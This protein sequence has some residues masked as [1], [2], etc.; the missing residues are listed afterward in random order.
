MQTT[1][2]IH[3]ALLD[4]AKRVAAER[5]VKLA[6]VVNDA[7]TAMLNAGTARGEPSEPYQMGTFKG[8]GP[9]PG[10]DFSSNASIQDA[11]DEDYRLPD[12]TFDLIRMK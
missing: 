2:D 1:I 10:I 8:T 6:D 3:D 9:A 11:L 12:G 4:R 7:L 5:G